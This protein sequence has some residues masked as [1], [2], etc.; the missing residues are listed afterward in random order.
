M[1]SDPPAPDEGEGEWRDEGKGER[2]RLRW[3]SL[4][5]LLFIGCALAAVLFI[6]AAS[7][8]KP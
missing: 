1:A 6:V 2:R 3:Q 5:F 4:I 8:I 7:F